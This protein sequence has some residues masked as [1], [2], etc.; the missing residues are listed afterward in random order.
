MLYRN[1]AEVLQMIVYRVEVVVRPEE[2]PRARAM[3]AALVEQSRT[4]PG[5]LHFDILQD[6]ADERRFVSVE[7]FAD[8][9]AVDRQGELPLVDEV[10]AAFDELLLEGPR[11]AIFGVSA[12]EPWP[13]T[14]ATTPAGTRWPIPRVAVTSPP[15]TFTSTT[16]IDYPRPDGGQ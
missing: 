13:G 10:L 3:F 11:G 5:V 12:T 1:I 6:P 9:A 15:E 2:L 7:V 16:P 4:V 8:R 14:T